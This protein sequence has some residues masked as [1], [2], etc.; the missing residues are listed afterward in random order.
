ME[1]CHCIIGRQLEYIINK[2]HIQQKGAGEKKKER[3][4]IFSPVFT[5]LCCKNIFFSQGQ[6]TLTEEAHNGKKLSYNLIP[7]KNLV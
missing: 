2:I 7:T 1:L 6:G 4:C 5:T 3:E